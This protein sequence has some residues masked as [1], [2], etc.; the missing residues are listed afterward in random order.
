[1]LSRQA[2]PTDPWIVY[3]GAGN[4]YE[5]A[6]TGHSQRRLT[7]TQARSYQPQ[8][9]PDGHWL[10]YIE[11][12]NYENY[13]YVIPAR[14]GTPTRI[15]HLELEEYT[16]SPDSRQ[17]AYNPRPDSPRPNTLLAVSI[18]DPTNPRYIA[19]GKTNAIQPAWSKHGLAYV[20]DG[21]IWLQH[22]D[23]TQYTLTN[24]MELASNSLRWAGEWLLF[25]AWVDFAHV[26]YRVHWQTLELIPM[27]GDSGWSATPYLIPDQTWQ[28]FNMADKIFRS[29]P[30]PD[31][32]PEPITLR[33]IAESWR[34]VLLGMSQNGQL[35][36]VVSHPDPPTENW[37]L[38]IITPDG[39][40]YRPIANIP[41]QHALETLAWSPIIEKPFRWWWLLGSIIGIGLSII[42]LQRSGF[43]PV[44]TPQ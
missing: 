1:M 39:A 15:A 16:W 41:A 34:A 36:A 23:G 42:L 2:T 3:S 26:A 4:L 25:G 8:Y 29:A 22:T 9:S 44:S 10:A 19:G 18:E 17:I 27:V 7:N 6:A 32:I 14:G 28:F 33:V 12:R 30:T 35:L 40:T 31:S 21:N 37:E 11:Q 13:L 38:A 24:N 5:V 43:Q 20:D